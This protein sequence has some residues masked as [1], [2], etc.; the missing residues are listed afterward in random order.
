MNP[1]KGSPSSMNGEA[2][3]TSAKPNNTAPKFAGRFAEGAF[4]SVVEGM[5]P[6]LGFP[7][8]G[9]DRDCSV[10]AALCTLD[11]CAIPIGIAAMETAAYVKIMAASWYRRPP[12]P[13]DPVIMAL[14]TIHPTANETY[15]IIHPVMM[16]TAA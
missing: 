12:M 15:A 16:P 1:W 13:P 11:A 5:Y 2:N 7:E 4:C 9:N 6:N 14:P 3:P 8:L 10:W